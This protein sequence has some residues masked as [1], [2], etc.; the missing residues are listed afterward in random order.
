MSTSNNHILIV[1]DEAKIVEVLR[2]LLE[3]AGYK[4]THAM[5]GEK[6]LLALGNFNPALVILDVMLP[7]I[8]GEEVCRRIRSS[9]LRIPVIM[10][11]ARV[12][13]EFKVR[14]LDFGADDYVTK[15]FSPKELLG[16]IRAVLRR[17]GEKGQIMADMLIFREGELEINNIAHEVRVADNPVNLTP[18]E[19]KILHTF[20]T[21]TK[22]VF[23]REE[24]VVAV[25]GYDY[26]G[27]DR[28]IDTHIKNLR[29]KL[30]Q[31]SS[32]QYI[33]TIHGVGYRFGGD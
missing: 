12:D 8:S 5:G 17:S 2:T 3:S 1:D 7:D 24:L 29:R 16:R 11:T 15:P 30:G 10:L 33:Q 22:R 26:E 20:L 14:C 18:I 21:N 23:S 27:Q 6:A 31:Y 25:W 19:Y 32:F 28:S 13:E 4:V 9:G